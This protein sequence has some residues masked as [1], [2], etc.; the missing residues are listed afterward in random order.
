MTSPFRLKNPWCA[1]AGIIFI[2]MIAA[3]S[4]ACLFPERSFAGEKVFTDLSSGHPAEPF[5]KYLAGQNLVIGYP[6]GTFRPDGRISR[7]EAAALLV[8]A[9]GQAIQPGVGASFSDVG[10]EHW[11]YGIIGAATGAGMVRGYPDGAFRPGDPVTR[12]QLSAMLFKMTAQPVPDVPLPPQVR[13]VAPGHWGR[14]VIAAALASGMLDMAGEGSFAPDAPATRGQV[15]RG[16][17]FMLTISPGRIKTSL[18]GKLAPAQGEVWV[19]DSGGDFR[20]VST[21]TE[22]GAGVTV[23]TGREGVAEIRF[24]DGSGL[25][26]DPE[27]EMSIKEARGL[28]A[29]LRDGSPGAKLDYLR[30][31]LTGGRLFGGLAVTDAA[32]A[33]RK[34]A[35]EST[36]N[37]GM[38]K[39]GQLAFSSG[40]LAIVPLLAQAE[41]GNESAAW[42]QTAQEEKVRVEIDMP[43]GV[44]GIR[45]TFWMNEVRPGRQVTTVVSGTAQLTASGQT[46]VIPAGW[47]SSVDSP[48]RLPESPS[49]MSGDQQKLWTGVEKWVKDRAVDMQSRSPV[50]VPPVSPG[51][52][53]EPRPPLARGILNQFLDSVSGVRPPSVTY[54]DPPDN[55]S[56]VNAEKVITVNFSED[57]QKGS[58]FE[59]IIVKDSA[60]AVVPAAK[61]L[62]GTSLVIKPGSRLNS[63]APV[64]GTISVEFDMDLTVQPGAAVRLTGGGESRSIKPR[65]SGKGLAVDYSG[66]AYDATYTVVIPAGTVRSKDLGTVNEEISWEFTTGP[67]PDR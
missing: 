31:E 13:D 40:K 64:S 4:F 32:R 52:P 54:T 37:T 57:I 50:T 43:W 30:L 34:G 47:S 14:G 8:K 12:A 25:R 45:G 3:L 26:L 28:S 63:G 65:V 53:A 59:Q 62:E 66:L 10:T 21:E 17:A 49:R 9:A 61:L 16:L 23:K 44:A 20:P 15:A 24:P 29:V 48:G 51:R 11:A 33:S 18:K 36:D 56:G 22:C 38:V 42:W 35:G 41:E 6:D 7:A 2:I 39:Q 5:V 1:L 46:I 55:A 58:S 27:T 60:G 67:N 19:R